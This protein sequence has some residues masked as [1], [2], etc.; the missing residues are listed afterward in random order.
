LSAHTI[1]LFVLK[2]AVVETGLRNSLAEIGM[3]EDPFEAAV[4]RELE[5]LIKQ[6][7]KSNRSNATKMSR[8]YEIF[9]M[10]ENEI[11][12]L[13]V[14]TMENAHGSDWWDSKVP[15]NVLEEVRKN[16]SREEELGVTARSENEIDYTTFGQL[17]DIIRENWPDF[18]GML[19]NVS[20][21]GRVMFALNN[22]RG[23]IAHCGLLA[24]DEVARLQ[25]AIHD[26][27]RV[28]QGPKS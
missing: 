25:L 24:D 26:W 17:G 13:I 19:S 23:T 16:I 11:R 6:F 1:E 22:L 10:L 2:C 21:V 28:L 7:E 27:F 8:Y 12:R 14:E 4:D 5:P 9:Y 18:A 15:K 3:R 20:A